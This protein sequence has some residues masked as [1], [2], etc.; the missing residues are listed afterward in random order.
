M[1]G[2]QNITINLECEILSFFAACIK[3]WKQA[4][5][6]IESE[7][8]SDKSG[9]EDGRVLVERDRTNTSQLLSSRSIEGNT[10][11]S[12]AV[13]LKIFE[14]CIFFLFRVVVDSIYAQK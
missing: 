11:L 13:A 9:V 14:T 3:I 4:A 7:G 1:S 5:G 8:C 6:Y 10:A 2:A 12:Q